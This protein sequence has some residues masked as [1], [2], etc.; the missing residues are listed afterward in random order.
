MSEVIPIRSGNPLLNDIPGMLR[1]MADWIESGE[2]VTESA[3]FI[4]P[5]E[6]SWPRVYGWGEGMTDLE[7]VANMELA[8][9]WFAN[10]RVERSS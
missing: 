4:L 2:V 5:V 9:L 7:C 6:D 8:K 1:Q 3:L 10:N